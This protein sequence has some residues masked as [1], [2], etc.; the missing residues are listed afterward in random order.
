VAR[1]SRESDPAGPIDRGDANRVSGGGRQPHSI[2][3]ELGIVDDTSTDDTTPIRSARARI[4]ASV[5]ATPA[6]D[7]TRRDN[8]LESRGRNMSRPRA[9]RGFALMSALWLVIAL[10]TLALELSVIARHRRLAVANTLESVRA[11]RAAASGIEQERARLGLLLQGSQRSASSGAE[12]VADPWWEADASTP[13]TVRLSDGVVAV[14]TA[15]DIG[16]MVNIN[17]VDQAGLERFLVASSVDAVTADALSQ[18]I[19]DW[20]DPDDFRRLR[21]A[22]RG[23]YLE[24]GARELPSNEPFASVD[25]LG[26]VRGM[27]RR[28]L[29]K[30]APQLT[31]F[32]SGQ[33]NVNRASEAVLLS[34]PGVTPLAASVIA[35]AQLGHRRIRN[36]RQLMDMLPLPARTS[37]EQTPAGVARLTFETREIEVRSRGWVTGSPIRVVENAVVTRAGTTPVVTWRRIE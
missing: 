27:T 24:S 10:S 11:E 35:G 7:P 34:V 25:E 22:E 30:I 14:V 5:A 19:M 8:Q 20:R 4:V 18:A 15:T 21:G 6:D 9:A 17:V 37:F 13:D 3:L 36:L 28:I 29:E 23:E 26:A 1:A 12:S 32:G 2:D 33:I 16:A 31:V